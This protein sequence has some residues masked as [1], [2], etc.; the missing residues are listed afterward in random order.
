MR[1]DLRLP[2]SQCEL[3]LQILKGWHFAPRL[4]SA[5]RKDYLESCIYILVRN[6]R[7][8]K[9]VTRKLLETNSLFW[10]LAAGA[11]AAR[12]YYLEIVRPHQARW[13]KQ[14]LKLL[15]KGDFDQIHRKAKTIMSRVVKTRSRHERTQG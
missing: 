7:F 10:G 1:V 4:L 2:V 14:G 3:A 12:V 6:V 13:G 5:R 11:M 9:Y 8:S 15:L